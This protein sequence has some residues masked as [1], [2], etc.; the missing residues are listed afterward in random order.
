MNVDVLHARAF[1]DNYIWLITS[2]DAGATENGQQSCVIVDP[3][4][5]DAALE[6]LERYHLQ[7]VAIFCTHYHGDHVGGLHELIKHFDIPAYGP[8]SESIRHLSHPVSGGE[9]IEVRGIG[10]FTVL[11]TPGHTPGHVSY[12]GGNALFCGD[13]LFSAGCGRLL[14]GTAPQ[15]Y[16][17]LRQLSSLPAET[18]VYCA[19][20]Y[21][22][23]NLVFAA[24]A[25]PGNADSENYRQQCQAQRKSHQ[26]TLPSTIGL[27][28]RVNPFLRTDSAA[29]RASTEA[30]AGHPLATGLEV[31]TELR[32]WKDGFAG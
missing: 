5:A 30:H 26:P 22:L 19:H 28:L 6:G 32:R 25:E 11:A 8:A 4:D 15:L 10:E 27:E 23:S 18:R 13:T 14:G 3:G 21:T 1:A 9:R 17:S 29:V 20:E 16:A 7:P 24:A 31:F 12:L 2:G